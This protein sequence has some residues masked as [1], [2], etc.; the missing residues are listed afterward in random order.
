MPILDDMHWMRL[1]LEEAL[2][3]H[4]DVPI[5]ALAVAR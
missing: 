4:G 2:V 1:A 5:G 3:E